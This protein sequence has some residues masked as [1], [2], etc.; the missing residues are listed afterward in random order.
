MESSSRKLIRVPSRESSAEQNLSSKRIL[1]DGANK[2]SEGQDHQAEVS[3]H[4]AEW[5]PR[6]NSAEL[7][8]TFS[9]MGDVFIIELS[10]SFS[11][12]KHFYLHIQG[13]TLELI[14]HLLSGPFSPHHRNRAVTQP[15]S[16][17]VFLR[18]KWSDL[19]RYQPC[20]ENWLLGELKQLLIL[21]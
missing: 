5:K 19:K 1:S 14:Y 21:Y 10:A 2:S 9:L 16:V 6:K 15:H 8:I 17:D 13:I 7:L 18:L 12:C 20:F 4:G 11:C 3:P